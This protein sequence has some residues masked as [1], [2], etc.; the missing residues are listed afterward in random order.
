[1]VRRL[2]L[3]PPSVVKVNK[4]KL[5]PKALAAHSR[6]PLATLVLTH[7]DTVIPLVMDEVL[8]VLTDRAVVGVSPEEMEVLVTPPGQL[9][10]KGLYQE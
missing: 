8:K 5:L 7:G 6:I 1:M 3:H 10:D 4:D 9:Q 2:G